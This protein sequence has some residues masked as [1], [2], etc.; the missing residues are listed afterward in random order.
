MIPAATAAR[1]ATARLV[2]LA[3]CSFLSASRY[4]AE[5]QTNPAENPQ[6]TSCPKDH[7]D[8]D[9]DDSD[10]TVAGATRCLSPRPRWLALPRLSSQAPPALHSAGAPPL[11]LTPSTSAH[12]H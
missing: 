1:A 3:T 11:H 2:M 7:D 5:T 6:L 9:D 4:L 10:L 8:D 12:R